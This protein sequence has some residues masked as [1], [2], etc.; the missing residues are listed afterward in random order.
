MGLGKLGVDDVARLVEPRAD[1]ADG[2]GAKPAAERRPAGVYKAPA[3]GLCM[4]TCYF[5]RRDAEGGE[6]GDGGIGGDADGA[7]PDRGIAWPGE[8][9]SD[10]DTGGLGGGAGDVDDDDGNGSGGG[11]QQEARPPP[12]ESATS[13]SATPPAPHAPAQD[14]GWSIRQLRIAN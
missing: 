4:H 7:W 8:G 12:P 2:P 6:R 14:D 10:A 9:A 11:G 1:P 3:R 5:R 13:S